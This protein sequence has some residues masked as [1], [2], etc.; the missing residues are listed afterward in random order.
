[1]RFLSCLLAVITGWQV[2]GVN[3]RAERGISE[4][5]PPPRAKFAMNLATKPEKSYK[6]YC[7]YFDCF[8]DCFRTFAQRFL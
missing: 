1:M 5:A 4:Y 3:P 8:A 2:A 7:I 6:V